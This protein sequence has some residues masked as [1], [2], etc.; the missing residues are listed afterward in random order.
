MG[1]GGGGEGAGPNLKNPKREKGACPLQVAHLQTY[2]YYF[3]LKA[4]KFHRSSQRWGL[5]R[6]CWDFSPARLSH[7]HHGAVQV[8][9]SPR[10]GCDLPETAPAFR[11]NVSLNFK[12]HVR[13]QYGKQ[14][15]PSVFPP[16]ACAAGSAP[17]WSSG[18]FLFIKLQQSQ[19]IKS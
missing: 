4:L 19:W 16:P 13:T 9:A 18:H 3:G 17:L 6:R 8:E 11:R 12:D 14:L 7:V 5:P 10:F 15:T 1:G 2:C